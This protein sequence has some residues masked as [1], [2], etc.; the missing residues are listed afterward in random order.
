MAI[1][2]RTSAGA[3]PARRLV[4]AEGSERTARAK[5]P[6]A[7]AVRRR[8]RLPSLKAVTRISF[9]QA[10][11]RILF[12]AGEVPIALGPV[13]DHR[14]DCAFFILDEL[15]PGSLHGEAFF[16]ARDERDLSL[17]RID[18][19]TVPFE[20]HHFARAPRAEWR[21]TGR[22]FIS[23]GI[24]SQEFGRNTKLLLELADQV[25]PVALVFTDI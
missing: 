6:T 7:R 11:S 15:N 23:T 18:H 12:P 8:P 4:L 17:S 19:E 3:R 21:R 13:L 5:I 1:K 20:E 14:G 22:S 9:T 24:L 10:Y 25:W 2:F 16:R